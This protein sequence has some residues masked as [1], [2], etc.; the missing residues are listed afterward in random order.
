MVGQ[1]GL[2]IATTLRNVVAISLRQELTPNPL[3]GR[4]A[5][6]SKMIA[7]GAEPIGALVGGGRLGWPARSDAGAGEDP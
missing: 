4:V 6:A 2:G 5:A 1:A 3:R 7:Y